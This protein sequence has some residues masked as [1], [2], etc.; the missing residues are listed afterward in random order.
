MIKKLINWILVQLRLRPKKIGSIRPKK[1]HKIFEF[2]YVTKDFNEAKYDLQIKNKGRKIIITNKNCIY[3]SALNKKN[4]A[5][6]IL[7]RL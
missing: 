3:V 4:A 5:K 2:N 1:G 6:K 7:K